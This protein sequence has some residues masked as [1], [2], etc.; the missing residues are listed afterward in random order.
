MASDD[1]EARVRRL[2]RTVDRLTAPASTLPIQSPISYVVGDPYDTESI[3][4][5]AARQRRIREHVMRLAR[6]HPL[7]PI[8]AARYSIFTLQWPVIAWAAL[9]GRE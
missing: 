3:D 9:V 5:I 8:E 4:A 2:E 1:I 7:L 6:T